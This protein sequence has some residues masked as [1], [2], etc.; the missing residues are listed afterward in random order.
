MRAFMK[1]SCAAILAL[2][3]TTFGATQARAWGG[4][5]GGWAVA[6][7]VLGGLAVGTAIGATVASASTPVYYTAPP[8]VYAGPSYY[9]AAP[10]YAPAYYYAPRVVYGAPYRCYYPCVRVGCGWGSRGYYGGRY[11]HRR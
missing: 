10:V 11:Y 7:G 8:A 5:C 9:G 6:G 3:M 2:A 1:T 4:G